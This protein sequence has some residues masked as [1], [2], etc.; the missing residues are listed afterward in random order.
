MNLSP[1]LRQR[2]LDN[3]GAPLAGGK[4]YSYVAGT[5][6]P[7]ATCSNSTGTANANP[8]V[9][10]GNGYADIWLDPTLSYKM[11]LKDASDATVWSVD[12]IS[13]VVGT[14]A[15]NWNANTT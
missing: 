9:L 7:L 15:L 14:T 10:D 2:F 3:N 11:I 5:T 12:N 13:Y 6:T 1:V 8:V 4:L